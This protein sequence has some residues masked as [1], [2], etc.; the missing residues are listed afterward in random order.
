VQACPF[1]GATEADR[2]TLEGRRFVV[3]ACSFTPEIDAGWSEEELSRRLSEEY[4]GG[5]SGAYFQRMCDRL[6]LYVTKGSGGDGLRAA[7]PRPHG[8]AGSTGT[9]DGS[10]TS[11]AA[12]GPSSG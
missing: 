4:P 2:F 7:S 6:H 9:A 11:A 3:F 12:G 1:C 10:E 8:P 5:T